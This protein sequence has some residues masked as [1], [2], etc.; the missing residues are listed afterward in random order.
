MLKP[1]NNWKWYFDTKTKSLMLDLGEY[2]YRVGITPRFLIE[3][4]KNPNS[5]SVDDA[6][7]YEN[8]V[9]AVACLDVVD[10]RNLEIALNA[11]A[12]MRF[13]KPVLPKSWFFT[14][15]EQYLTPIGGQVV[16]LSNSLN[17][18]RFFVV[19]NFGDA[20]MCCCIEESFHLNDRKE[21]R[22]GEM[23]KVMNNRM[24]AYV[25]VINHVNY[26]QVG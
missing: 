20:S 12:S 4:A 2:V 1:N 9:E 7:H 10:N 18:G 24:F 15:S 21:I 5:F 26:A 3:D 13:H 23:I 17:Q 22:L 14:T 19:E 6:L 8:F 25:P 16:T 11:V